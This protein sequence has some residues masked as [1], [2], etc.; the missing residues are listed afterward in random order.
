[1]SVVQVQANEVAR[2]SKWAT[3]GL[4]PNL[5]IIMDVP[6]EIGLGRLNG[7]DRLEQEPLAFHERVRREFLNLAAID[8]D[9][10]FVVD[11]TQSKEEIRQQIAS[12]VALIP[13]LALNESRA[14]K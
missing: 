14:I 10:Y 1:M 7:A 6:A 8:P 9:R 4:I 13:Q 12:R 5:T 11:A 3:D 2:L